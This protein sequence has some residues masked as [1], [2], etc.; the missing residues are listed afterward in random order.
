LR[1]T[2][3]GVAPLATFNILMQTIFAFQTFAAPYTIFDGK[4]GPLDSTLLYVIYLYRQG[5]KNFDMGYASTLSWMLLCM[6]SAMAI[7]I[8]L[9]DKKF[10]NYD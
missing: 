2:L 10:V 9:L 4:G 8:Y 3:P 6:I 1:I 5:F 7:L